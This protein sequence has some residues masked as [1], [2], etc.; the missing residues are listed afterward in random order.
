[1]EVF[2]GAVMVADISGFTKLTEELSKRASGFGV[3]LLT[4]CMNSFF[5]K[6][7]ALLIL[8]WGLRSSERTLEC[9]ALVMHRCGIVI[10][11][12]ILHALGTGCAGCPSLK[13]IGYILSH[14]ACRIRYCI[15]IWKPFIGS[16]FHL[17][18]MLLSTS[19][20]DSPKRS[21]W[22]TSLLLSWS[23]ARRDASCQ[24]P[25]GVPPLASLCPCQVIDMILA[26]DG[27]VVKFAGDSM[28]IAFYPTALEA[29]AAA[30]DQLRAATLRCVRCASDLSN[31]LGAC[32]VEEG[33]AMIFLGAF[34]HIELLV[35]W[36]SHASM[37]GY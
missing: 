9:L 34:R 24:R 16:L 12:T 19:H 29:A 35:T 27:D 11:D 2:E 14:L 28:I 17:W 5:S 23:P 32:H 25:F 37:L 36:T 10:K 26:Y 33:A 22:L 6:A 13:S 15:L 20:S 4:K 21:A 7:C 3:E 18:S 31:T 8:P 1:M 30:S